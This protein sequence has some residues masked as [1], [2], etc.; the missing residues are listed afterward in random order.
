MPPATAPTITPTTPTTAPVADPSLNAK[1][2]ESLSDYE[3]RLGATSGGVGTGFG[4]FTPAKP[5]T[6]ISSA[7]D[8]VARNLGFNSYQDA[9]QKLSV[10]QSTTDFYNQAYSAAGLDAL[11]S[12]IT[13]R[14]N[15]LADATGKVNDNPWLDEASRVG[16]VKNLQTLANADIKNLQ[17]EYNAKLKSVH[18]LVTQHDTD[19]KNNQAKLTLLESQAKELAAQA[20]T[21]TKTD[22]AAPKTIKGPNGATYQWDPNTNSFK[23]ILPG[24]TTAPT[25]STDFQFTSKQLLQ[26]QTK[27]LNP[28]DVNNIL[29]DIKAGHSL[30][31]IRNQMKAGGLDPSLLDDIVNMINGKSSTGTNSS[32]SIPGVSLDQNGAQP[33]A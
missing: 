2:G 3:G 30:D 26:L 17:D 24:K 1:P 6:D 31:D 7:Q 33:F 12:Q 23:Q 20:A 27:G 11:Q 19:V 15:D 9:I 8:E 13:S 16:R 5:V 22:N 14:Q 18:D 10:N 21:Q 25:S 28:T 32:S 29:G 4:A